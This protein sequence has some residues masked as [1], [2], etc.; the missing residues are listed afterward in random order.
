[1]EDDE[2]EMSG[3]AVL[4]PRRPGESI[5]VAETVLK[6]RDRNLKAAAERAH[7]IA[8][9]RQQQK[10]YKKGKLNIIRPETLVKN[11]M[12]RHHDRHRVKILGKKP[13]KGPG[14][15]RVLAVVRN[16]RMGG[17]HE[18]KAAMKQLGLVSRHTLIFVPNTK[19]FLEKLQIA[20][21]F[22]FWGRPAFKVVFNVVHKK[23]IFRDPEGEHGRTVLSDNVLIEKHLGDLGVL[24]T[25]DLAHVIHTCS[26]TFPKVTDRLW[27]VPVGDSKKAN[28][29]VRDERYTFGHLSDGINDKITALLGE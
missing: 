14:P 19:E 10:D 18:V 22:L 6:R 1:M 15:G 20:R 11:A 29:L 9:N 25:E 24:C 26:K 4:R 7:A 28:G 17:S 3:K 13:M 23:A 12:V 5:K 27:P 16:G 2:P 21:P 8:R